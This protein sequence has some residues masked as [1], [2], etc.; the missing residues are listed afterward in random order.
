M[1]VALQLTREQIRLLEVERDLEQSTGQRIFVDMSVSEVIYSC[2]LAGYHSAAAAVRNEFK[3]P[4]NRCA[5]RWHAHGRR[6]WRREANP[7][8][9]RGCTLEIAVSC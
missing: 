7:I 6:R 4:D 9:G 2:T 5:A 1:R 8:C 3:V